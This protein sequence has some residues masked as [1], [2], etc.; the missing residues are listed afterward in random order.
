M[1]PSRHV[2]ARQWK[3]TLISRGARRLATSGGQ[4]FASS[5]ATATAA[6]AAAPSSAG[7]S[8]AT[9]DWFDTLSVLYRGTTLAW[10]TAAVDISDDESEAVKDVPFSE[11][12]E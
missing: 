9:A 7:S 1:P 6:A 12:G 5:A 10:P 3:K 11:D 2:S 8:A 4:T